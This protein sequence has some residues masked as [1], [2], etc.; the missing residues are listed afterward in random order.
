ML[1]EREIRRLHEMEVQLRLTDPRLVRRFAALQAGDRRRNGAGRPLHGAGP[2][3]SLLLGLS[4][5]VLLVGA[6]A[7]SVPTVI[8]GVVLAAVSLGLA[9]TVGSRSRPDTA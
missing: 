1:S 5:L 7:V 2:L 8:A 9:A 6:V 4:L 3:H